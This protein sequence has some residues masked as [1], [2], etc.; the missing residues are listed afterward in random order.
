[1]LLILSILPAV[2]EVSDSKFH[3]HRFCP[4]ISVPRTFVDR[5]C[6]LLSEAELLL[7][8]ACFHPCSAVFFRHRATDLLCPN[9]NLRPCLMVIPVSFLP[10]ISEKPPSVLGQNGRVLN[11]CFAHKTRIK[12]RQYI[13]VR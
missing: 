9:C 12:R 6:N 10:R 11:S 1:M 4:S 8:P 5:L 7:I 2:P 13:P 3:G